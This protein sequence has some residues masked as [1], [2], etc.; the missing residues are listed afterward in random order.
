MKKATMKDIAKLA[1]VSIATVSYVL[2][3]VANQTIPESTR[4]LIL[5]AAQE[6]NYIPNLAARSL[7]KRKSGL[8]GILISKENN[9][10][11]WKSF[12]YHSFVNRLEKLLTTAGYHTLLIT[13]DPA[14]PSLDIIVERKLEAVIL[15]DVKDE[16]FY[17]ISS[18][19]TEGIPLILIDCLIEDKLF[20]HIIYDYRSAIVEAANKID[21]ATAL[22]MEDFHNKALVREIQSLSGLPA[23]NIFIAESMGGL[24]H[25]I[26]HTTF[27]NL[28]IINE[29]IGNYIYHT[30]QFNNL[31]VI[32]TCNYPEILPPTLAKVIYEEDKSTTAFELMNRLI[33]VTDSSGIK[34][35]K[36]LIRVL[37]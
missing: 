25:F 1:N 15:I 9:S 8:I 11:F 30:K 6:L 32:C 10:P 3:N 7:I 24:E 29:F 31:V 22:V 37:Q 2:N 17:N 35:N 16:L 23:D 34:D 20:N 4:S 18:K 27:D 12:A 33:S 13:L 21:G 14:H 5:E 26:K 19:F 36:F 28:I